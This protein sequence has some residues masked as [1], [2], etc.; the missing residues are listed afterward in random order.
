MCGSRLHVPTCDAPYL[1][2]NAQALVT[3]DRKRFPN[4]FYYFFKMKFRQNNFFCIWK[5]FEIFFGK[6]K[7]IHFCSEILR[8][9]DFFFKFLM[10]IWHF[11]LEKKV[12]QFL[13]FFINM[14]LRWNKIIEIWNIPDSD[15]SNWK[16]VHFCSENRGFSWTKKVLRFLFFFYQYEA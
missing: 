3:T 13:F 11:F 2:P 1:K 14:K 6:W 8:F 10:G 16:K 15:F 7:K 12:L 9:F 5:I 4:F